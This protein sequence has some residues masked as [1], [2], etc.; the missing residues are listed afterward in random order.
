MSLPPGLPSESLHVR[1]A[2]TSSGGDHDWLPVISTKL[3]TNAFIISPGPPQKILLGYKKRGFGAHFYNGFGGKVEAGES[4]AQAAARELKEECGVE[5]SLD[6]CGTLLFVNKG[7]PE[8]AFQIEIY[9]ADGYS[10]T[11]I[12]TEEMRPEWFSAADTRF[13]E[14]S[15]TPEVIPPPIPY[16]SMWPDDIYWIPLL[17]TKLPFVGRADFDTDTSGR[18][19]M[20]RWWFGVPSTSL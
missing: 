8:W 18:Y 6:H 11:L 9:R 14:T 1:Y 20:L 16:N 19:E 4:P 7:G 17:L 15:L 5:A 10:G 3:Y 2:E 13:S 12:E